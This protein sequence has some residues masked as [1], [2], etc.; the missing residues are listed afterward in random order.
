MNFTY[1]NV[2]FRRYSDGKFAYVTGEVT[3]ETLKDYN[4][5]V[6]RM[7]LF[8]M[9][10]RVIWSG[11]FKIR[12]LGKKRTKSFEVPLEG[13]DFTVIPKISRHDIYFEA[14]Y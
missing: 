9:G 11:S 13:V 3:N 6:F 5:A 14:G 2:D 10:N 4:T 1:Y 8:D 7:V 12:G